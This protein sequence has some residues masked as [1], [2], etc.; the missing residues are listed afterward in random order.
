MGGS[1]V[2]GVRLKPLPPV[3]GNSARVD[4]FMN[5]LHRGGL[6]GYKG[7]KD[8]EFKKLEYDL[9]SA[10]RSTLSRYEGGEIEFLSGEIMPMLAKLNGPLEIDRLLRSFIMA[11]DNLGKDVA[12]IVS[13]MGHVA[14]HC[15][16]PEKWPAETIRAIM[17]VKAGRLRQD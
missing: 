15:N 5:V 12:S 17:V 3:E 9:G 14:T 4:I 16:D 10:L 1:N 6:K 8:R 2:G 7:M 13:V 11:S